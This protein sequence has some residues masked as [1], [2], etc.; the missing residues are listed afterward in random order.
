M[1]VVCFQDALK[2]WCTAGTDN[3]DQRGSHVAGFNTKYSADH[4]AAVETGTGVSLDLR[5]YTPG[6]FELLHW[7]LGPSTAV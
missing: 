5:P 2:G 3:L 7:P 6:R 1:L 4:C